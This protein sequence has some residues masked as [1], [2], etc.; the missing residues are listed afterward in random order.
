[1]WVAF[2]VG[3]MLGAC[4][5]ILAIGLCQMDSLDGTDCLPDVDEVENEQEG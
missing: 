3:L 4:A 1:M 5:G 2:G